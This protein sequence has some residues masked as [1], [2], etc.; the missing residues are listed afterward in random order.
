M[1]YFY[2]EYTEEDI[3]IIKRQLNTDDVRLTG[4]VERCKW[5]CPSIIILYPFRK[6]E[7]TEPDQKKLNYTSLSTL[8]WLTCP[9]LNE[10]IH[11]LESDGYIKK[12][13]VFVHQ[14]REYIEAMKFAHAHYFFLRKNIYR[15]FLGEVS[16]L[17]ENVRLFGTGIGGINNTDTIKCLHLHYAHYRMCDSNFAGRVTS[18]LLNNDIYCDN[19]RCCEQSQERVLP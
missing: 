5:G 17:E 15:H 12:I 6:P 16:S 3:E 4:I 11:R 1:K 18:M 10:R 13:G 8:V 7:S 14:E 2:R 9:Y 19:C